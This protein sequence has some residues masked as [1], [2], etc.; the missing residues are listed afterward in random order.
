MSPASRPRPP[1][2]ASHRTEEEQALLARAK[3]LQRDAAQLPKPLLGKRLGLMSAAPDSEDAQL[4]RQAA[5]ELGAHVALI[6]A[7]TEPL[8]GDADP[9]PGVGRLLGRLYDAVE[10]QGLSEAVVNDLAA[11]ARIPIYAGLAGHGHAIFRLARAWQT[12]APLIQR[13]HWLVQ[14]TLLATLS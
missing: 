8:E 11:V 1:A 2:P 14:A 13:R 4:F 6:P 12:S 10:C 9:L 5:Q 7:A 3:A